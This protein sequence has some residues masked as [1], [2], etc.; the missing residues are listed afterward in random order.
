[1][2]P[3]ALIAKRDVRLG[4]LLRTEIDGIPLDLAARLLP[5]RTRLNFGL[6]S[7][8]HLHARSQRRHAADAEDGAG[9]ESSPRA[10]AARL[11]R[12]RL[13]ALVGNLRSTVAG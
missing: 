12:K 11:P 5:W 9:R 8:V 1:L 3:L 13:V 7:H 4:D 10:S 2:A 6:L